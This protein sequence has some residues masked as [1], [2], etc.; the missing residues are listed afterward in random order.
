MPR[1]ATRGVGGQNSQKTG[2]VVYGC[3]LTGPFS[4]AVINAAGRLWDWHHRRQP[5]PVIKLILDIRLVH[6]SLTILN[7]N[8]VPC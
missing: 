4:K 1:L 3:P 7:W 6:I 8:F 5:L 2:H